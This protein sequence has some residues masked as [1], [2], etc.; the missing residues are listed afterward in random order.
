M[1]HGVQRLPLHGSLRASC[2]TAAGLHPLLLLLA[3][4]TLTFKQVQ[5]QR[6]E[7][8]ASLSAGFRDFLAH[9]QQGLFARQLHETTPGFAAASKQARLLA[10]PACGSSL[11]ACIA[12]IAGC[13]RLLL[14]RTLDVSQLLLSLHCAAQVIAIEAQLRSDAVGRPDLAAL[15]RQVQELERRKLQMTLSW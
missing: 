4:R 15:L 11:H 9:G 10:A 6:A 13:I 8:Y 14:R 7:L 12:G 2:I 5:S 3:L 1:L